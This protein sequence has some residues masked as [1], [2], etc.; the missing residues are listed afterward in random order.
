MRFLKIALFFL[1][2]IAFS[3]D[4][5]TPYEKGNGNQSTTYDECISYYKNLDTQFETI[6]MKEMGLTHS[7]EPLH[8]VTFSENKNSQYS[9]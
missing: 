5:K 2:Y 1:S 6:S 8:I 7:G 4:L 9:S 3:Q